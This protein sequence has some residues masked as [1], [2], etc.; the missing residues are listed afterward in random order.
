MRRIS[1]IGTAAAAL[2]F[3]ANVSLS[4][5]APSFAGKWTRVD[6][7]AAQG[8]GGG[9]GGGRGGGGGAAFNCG[10]ECTIVQDAKTLTIT[11]TMAGR[12]G[13]T[14][15]TATRTI[16]LGG[17]GTYEMPG[18]GG[19]AATT[20]NTT[21]KVDGAKLIITATR[22][23]GGN[24]VTTTQTLSMEGGNLV[25][26]TQGVGREGAPTTTKTTYKKGM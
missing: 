21:A 3:A 26:E 22:D 4:A 11:T 20:V 5:Q 7:P 2:L 9:R 14:P 12:E 18:R 8:G 25:V 17:P 6:D 23:M 13:G 1:M 10:A 15:T 24:S 16:T 19:G